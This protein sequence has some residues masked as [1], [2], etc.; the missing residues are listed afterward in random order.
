MEGEREGEREGFGNHCTKEE[1]KVKIGK[2][3]AEYSAQ[4]ENLNF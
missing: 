3:E 4:P 1:K 2:A